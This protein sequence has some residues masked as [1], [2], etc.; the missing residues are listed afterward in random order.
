[1]TAAFYLK[2]ELP[3]KPEFWIGKDVTQVQQ[4]FSKKYNLDETELKTTGEQF[5]KLVDQ[6]MTWT[7]G[8]D[9]QCSVLATP[10]HTPACMSYRIGDA[11]FVGDTLFM[12]A[13]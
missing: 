13:Y 6:D 11:A 12:V 7:L 10:G 9:I 2:H 4:V 1:L 3:T 5:D 8:K